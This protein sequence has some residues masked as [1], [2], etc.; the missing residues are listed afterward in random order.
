MTDDEPEPLLDERRTERY[1]RQI[2]IPDLGARGQARLC[3]ATAAIVGESPGA[4]AAR[5][6]LEAAGLTV[7]SPPYSDPVDC[8][9]I[10]DVGSVRAPDSLPPTAP[11]AAVGWYAL[12]G[13][14]VRGG[15]TTA[16][17]AIATCLRT[18]CREPD[19]PAIAIALHRTGGA[20]A[21]ATVI[22]ALLG[23]TQPPETHEIAL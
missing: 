22:A 19:D 14:T 16:S 10:T 12:S 4:S 18:S 7:V 1:A 8:V 15:T 23:W 6:Y 17:D 9:V 2:I 5:A 11:G 13:E 21:A 3:A 20:D